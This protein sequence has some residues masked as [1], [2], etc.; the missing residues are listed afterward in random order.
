MPE[1][2]VLMIF[3]TTQYVTSVWSTFSHKRL[4]RSDV[5]FAA[6][7]ALYR[8]QGFAPSAWLECRLR[9]IRADLH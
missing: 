7:I 3:P 2:V 5:R 6:R 1:K 8:S 4:K 9:P